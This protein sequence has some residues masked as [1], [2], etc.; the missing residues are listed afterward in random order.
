MRTFTLNPVG[1][2]PSNDDQSDGADESPDANRLILLVD[3]PSVFLDPQIPEVQQILVGSGVVHRFYARE[4]L[5]WNG[6]LVS[7]I[8]RWRSFL[9]VR[10]KPDGSWERIGGAAGNFITLTPA[11]D[12]ELPGFN[13]QDAQMV[14]DP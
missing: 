6:G 9:T 5:T 14:I 11:N 13:A 10:R 3:V 4:W 12:P 7:T 1:A 8:Q 2:P